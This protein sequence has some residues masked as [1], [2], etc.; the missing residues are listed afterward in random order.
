MCIIA[1]SAPAQICFTCFPE[2]IRTQR[3]ALDLKIRSISNAHVVRKGLNIFRQMEQGSAPSPPPGSGPRAPL[4]IA[5][6]PGVK[7]ACWT[8]EQAAVGRPTC[9]G[10]QAFSIGAGT[11]REWTCCCACRSTLTA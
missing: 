5:S 4:D 1:T 10:D 9:V 6:I 8:P 11:E 7:E 3:M 2:M